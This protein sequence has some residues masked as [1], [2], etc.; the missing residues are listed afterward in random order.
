[1]RAALANPIA[2]EIVSAANFAHENIKGLFVSIADEPNARILIQSF[3]AHQLLER[4]SLALIF[5]GDTFRQVTEPSFTLD[6]KL[7]AI[8][9]NGHLKFKSFTLIK[10]IFSLAEVYR[11]ATDQQIEDFCGHNSLEVGNLQLF[12]SA[13]DQVIRKLVHAVS[14]SN[15][16]DL[17]PVADIQAK[18]NAMGIEITIDNGRIVMPPERQQIKYLLHFLDNSIYEGPLNAT[19]LL[20]SGKRAFAARA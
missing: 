8:A 9:E 11:I 1:M 13:A 17:C 15:V 6:G 18:A 10:R 7:V 20:A 12:K 4:S 19:L 3:T 5:D 2:L 14:S 16:L